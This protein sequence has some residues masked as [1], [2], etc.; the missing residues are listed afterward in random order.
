MIREH[1]RFSG[2][3]YRLPFWIEETPQAG[4]H[5]GELASDFLFLARKSPYKGLGLV[6]EAL[7][8]LKIDGIRPQL[9][10]AGP[11]GDDWIRDIARSQG[12][13]AQL[14]I[15]FFKQ[16]QT[17]M[18][19]LAS[20]KCLLLP[21][22]HEGYPLVMLEALSQGTPIIGSDTGGVGDMLGRTPGAVVLPKPTVDALY[23]AMRDRWEKGRTGVPAEE[24]KALRH[25]FAEIN[26]PAL[27]NDRLAD[28][29]SSGSS[30]RG[31]Q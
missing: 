28:L 1:Y 18:D 14:R 7:A 21:S 6:L 26:S 16:R 19:A 15:T 25:R 11:G 27:I 2:P 24:A 8:R 12:V 30:R 3:I 17:I 31:L 20:T 13:E 9:I 22:L 29:V 4:A 10:V 23:V 5:T